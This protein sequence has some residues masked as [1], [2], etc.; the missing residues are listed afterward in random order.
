M[1]RVALV[2]DYDTNIPARLVI[3]KALA[4]TAPDDELARS[5]SSSPRDRLRVL[6]RPSRAASRGGF[7]QRFWWL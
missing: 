1:E 5:W 2:G 7:R 6:R 3:P 4:A